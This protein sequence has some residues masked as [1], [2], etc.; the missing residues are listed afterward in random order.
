MKFPCEFHLK[1]IGNNSQNF[2]HQVV[3]V[4]HQ[5]VP[6]LSEAAIQQRTSKH[7]KYRALSIK[8]NARRQTQL[9]QL[10]RSLNALPDVTMVL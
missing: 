7:S 1:V 4:L 8:I 2:E 9:D 10:Y 6:D 5:H 3:A